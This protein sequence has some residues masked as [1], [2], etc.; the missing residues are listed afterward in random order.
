[1][2][3][4]YE[5]CLRCCH[6]GTCAAQKE[7]LYLKDHRPVQAASVWGDHVVG[8]ANTN[9][10]QVILLFV[11]RRMFGNLLWQDHGCWLCYRYIIKIEC[12]CQ[13]EQ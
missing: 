3:Q 9:D 13:C 1:M 5:C 12:E 8:L 11:S 6:R 4:V 2:E 7:E 10:L